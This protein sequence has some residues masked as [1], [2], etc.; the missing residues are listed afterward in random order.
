MG[1]DGPATTVD[2]RGLV[3]PMP[4]LKAKKGIESV[5]VGQ[6]LELA[7]TDPGSMADFKAWTKT[8][9]HELLEAREAGGV[10]TYLIRRKK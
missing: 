3:C 5:E 1:D 4:I 2:A 8:T 7:A 6:I 9:G 10:Y